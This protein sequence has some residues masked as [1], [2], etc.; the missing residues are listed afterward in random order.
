MNKTSV[1]TT[2]SRANA[3]EIQVATETSI[4][5]MAAT[6]LAGKLFLADQVKT[7]IVE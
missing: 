5:D 3:L 7:R 4:A 2:V 1:S 6:K